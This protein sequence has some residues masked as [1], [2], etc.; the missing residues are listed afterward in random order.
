MT[1]EQRADF[2]WAFFISHEKTA[3]RLVDKGIMPQEDAERIL[4][5]LYANTQEKDV[6]NFRNSKGCK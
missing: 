5:Q 2:Y 4:E 1:P 6:E 3:K